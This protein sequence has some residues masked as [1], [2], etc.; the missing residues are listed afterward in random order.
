MVNNFI[1]EESLTM[2]IDLWITIRGF[3]YAMQCLDK[4]TNKKSVQ[5]IALDS[6]AVKS[7]LSGTLPFVK[8]VQTTV[9]LWSPDIL[10]IYMATGVG[11]V[12][13]VPAVSS[14]CKGSQATSV[15]VACITSIYGSR[16]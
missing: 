1:L 16:K 7:S 4:V 8:L 11:H 13:L 2:V 3:S 5:K 14:A 6:E 12:T 15:L 9:L 10:V